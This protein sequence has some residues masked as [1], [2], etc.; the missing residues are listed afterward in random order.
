M[1]ELNNVQIHRNVRVY[2]PLPYKLLFHAWP[3][4]RIDTLK[5]ERNPS[6]TPS[7]KS[8]AHSRTIIIVH[9]NR[10]IFSSRTDCWQCA[11]CNNFQRWLGGQFFSGKRGLETKHFHSHDTELLFL[12]LQQTFR[13][14]ASGHGL[15]SVESRFQIT[16]KTNTTLSR[17]S[18]KTINMDNQL[19]WTALIYHN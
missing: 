17:H 16:C 6:R 1:H 13:Y 11:S 19:I 9:Y 14:L 12:V 2:R 3:L 10:L 15:V 5:I 4:N 7:T 18:V 8:L